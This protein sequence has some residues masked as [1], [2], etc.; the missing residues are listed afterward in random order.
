MT[1]AQSHL[2]SAGYDELIGSLDLAG[3]VALL[4]GASMFT[5]VPAPA[6]GL[7]ELRFSDGPTGV[8]GLKF[9]GEPGGRAVPQRHPA[10]VGLERGHRVP[11]RADAG[12]GGAGPADPRGAR[13][14]HQPAPH[15]AGRPAVRGLFRGPAADRQARGR[16]RA[17]AAG[18]RRGRLP[19]APG[20]QRVRDRAAHGQQRGRRG[21]AARALPAAVR[22][23]RRRVGCL[24]DDG[25]LQRRQRGPGDGAGPRHQRDRQGRVGLS[26]P[27]DVGLVRHQVGRAGR[28]RRPGPGDARAARSLGPGPGPGGPGRRGGRGGHR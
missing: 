7:G 13:A 20:R 28:S 6:I 8:R 21:H 11:G 25:R 16:L 5:L 19:Q 4:T 12:A 17:R 24:V 3:K 26:R 27:G 10:G 18:Q 9:S 14:D 15:P 1:T 2:G 23:R 22:D